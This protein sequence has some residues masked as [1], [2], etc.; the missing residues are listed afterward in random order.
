MLDLLTGIQELLVTKEVGV[1]PPIT[2]PNA[3][4]IFVGKAPA[5]PSGSISVRR[6]TGLD[7]NPKYLLDYPSIQIMVRGR[8]NEYETASIKAQLIK[9]TLLG[10]P[11]QTIKDIRWVLINMIGDINDLGTDDNDCPL[12]SLNFQFIIEPP[13]SVDSNRIPL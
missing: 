6:T 7:S 12:M 11:S 13:E 10:L 9:D 5:T 2:D 1:L 8:P 4:G 3:Y